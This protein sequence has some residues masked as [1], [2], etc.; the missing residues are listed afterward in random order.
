MAFK[1]EELSDFVDPTLP[2]PV[3]DASLTEDPSTNATTV[4]TTLLEFFEQPEKQDNGHILHAPQLPLTGMLQQK[5]PGLR[6]LASTHFSWQRMCPDLLFPFHEL[7]NISVSMT[8]SISPI[9]IEAAGLGTVIQVMVGAV[10]VYLLQPPHDTLE[11]A[12]NP[13]WS[14]HIVE[15]MLL[16]P[17]ELL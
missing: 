7:V 13:D 9:R 8:N 17:G 6:H 14:N 1:V 15:A 4:T 2:I 5:V 12:A 16:T 10:V 3:Y 11:A